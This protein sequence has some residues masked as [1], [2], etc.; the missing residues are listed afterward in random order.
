MLLTNLQ[1]RRFLLANQGLLGSTPF[2]GKAGALDYIRRAG[3]IQYDPIDVCG[4]NA[5]LTLQSR[6]RGCKKGDLEE[7]LYRDFAL[8]DY[9][10]KELSILPAEDWPCLSGYRAMSIAHGR[11]FPGLDALEQQAIDYIANYGPVSADMLPIE[12]RIFWHSSMHWSGNWH[13]ESDAARSVLEQL[14]TDGVLLIHHK[15]GSRKFYDLASRHLPAALLEAPSPFPDELNYLCW[16]VKRRIGAVGLLWDRSSDAL[17]GVGVPCIGG[18]HAKMSAEER[19]A[20]FSALLERDEI[21]PVAVEGIHSPFYLCSED[22][23]L[24][25]RVLHGELAPQD[26]C[27]FL[28]P[29]DP[30]LWDRRLIRTLFGFDYRWEIYTPAEKR[31]YGYYVLPVLFRDRFIGRIEPVVDR[32][33]NILQIEHLWLEPGVRQTK[34]LDRAL[35]SAVDRFARFHGCAA[36]EIP[37]PSQPNQEV[38]S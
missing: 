7:L 5:E 27:A 26:R 34:A 17:L 38:M 28:A 16:R 8:V 25:E 37:S 12:G 2:R 24:L 22:L 31:T 36:G 18:Y 21:A 30:M 13:G 10:D 4:R 19:S 23:P 6:V 9:V 29:L 11:T 15:N 20:V 14:Y 32:K 1:A 35:R 3:C 33:K